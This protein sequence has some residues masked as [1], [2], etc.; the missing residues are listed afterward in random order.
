MPA[1]LLSGAEGGRQEMFSDSLRIWV[2]APQELLEPALQE[3]MGWD[4]GWSE[5]QRGH[6]K[7]AATIHD[8]GMS[9]RGP[10]V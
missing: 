6:S 2:F 7:T 8:N 1:G 5:G 3:G 4:H 9:Q 10:G